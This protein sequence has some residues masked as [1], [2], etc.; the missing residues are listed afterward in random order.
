MQSRSHDQP[1]HKS[2]EEEKMTSSSKE[3]V[4]VDN[5]FGIVTNKRLTYMA[6]KSWFS[7][8]RREDVPLKQVVA[9]RYEMDRKV[10][11]GLLLIVLGIVL[12]T[13]VVGIIPLIVGIL[14]MWGSP[15]VNDG[16]GKNQKQRRL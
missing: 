4:L 9:V 12:I 15:T 1:L 14:L 2:N 13:V 3:N 6:K 16:H 7:G 10:F 5:C 11:G 8:G